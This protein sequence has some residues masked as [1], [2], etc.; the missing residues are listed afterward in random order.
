MCNLFKSSSKVKEILSTGLT[1]AKV[2]SQRF[3]QPF[4]TFPKHSRNVI[5]RCY[6]GTVRQN[7]IQ[8]SVE[9]MFRLAYM[10]Y[11]EFVVWL[12]FYWLILVGNEWPLFDLIAYFGWKAEIFN[13]HLMLF[14]CLAPHYAYFFF[15]NKWP[16]FDFTSIFWLECWGHFKF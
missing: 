8:V 14:D 13:A 10:S 16:L 1:L 5:R 11:I 15:G 3:S 12:T 9:C 4:N 6:G 2:I 7:P